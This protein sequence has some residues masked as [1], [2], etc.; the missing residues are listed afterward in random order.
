MM[1]VVSFDPGYD[2]LGVAIVEGDASKQEVVYSDC[3][4]TNAKE[5]FPDRLYHLGKHVND[6]IKTHS[7]QALAIETLFFNTNQKTAMHVA[8]ARGMLLYLGGVHDMH[9]F[10][11][12]P[13][14]IKSAVTGYG[15]SSKEQVTSMVKQLVALPKKKMLDDEYDAIAVG[16]TCLA[17]ERTLLVG[18]F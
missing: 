5:V 1:R 16:I 17:S 7:P 13:I 6:L 11:Y 18:S 4:Q 14:Q 2:R 15:K 9:V 3:L 8:E 12:T 10:E